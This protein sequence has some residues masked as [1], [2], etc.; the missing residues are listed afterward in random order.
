MQADHLER[1]IKTNHGLGAD[2]EV[3]VTDPN[4]LTGSPW[5]EADNTHGDFS[6]TL[7]F[8]TPEPNILQLTAFGLLLVVTHSRHRKQ[9]T[10]PVLFPESL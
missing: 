6:P 7:V 9:R 1:R 8:F 4:N 10:P 3:R 2:A 5:S